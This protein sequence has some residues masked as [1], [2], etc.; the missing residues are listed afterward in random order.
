MWCAMHTDHDYFHLFYDPTF[1][2]CVPAIAR[3]MYKCNRVDN[4]AVHVKTHF[5]S[6]AIPTAACHLFAIAA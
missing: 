1:C 3:Y 6:D 4:S 5:G 2:M